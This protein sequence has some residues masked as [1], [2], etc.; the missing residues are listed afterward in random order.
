MIIKNGNIIVHMTLVILAAGLS[1]R[2]GEKN[3]LLLPFKGGALIENAVKE[4]LKFTDNV[5][6][7][8]GY[9][10]ELIEEALKEYRVSFLRNDDYKRGQET[11]IRKAIDSL[12]GDLI[13]TPADLPLLTAS[14]FEEAAKQLDGFLSARACFEGKIG[15]PV[16]IS[17]AL[18]PEIRRE[19]NVRVRDI[20]EKRSHNFYESDRASVT[21]I[22]TP[23]DWER[24]LSTY[25][26]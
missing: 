3:K 24:F 23:L 2:M 15:H 22:D 8:T 25:S 7:V 12:E 10:S 4:A 16:A 13:L 11:S 6:V 18:I 5:T 26:L 20:M 1:S 14:H 9:E 17:G 19:R 21:D